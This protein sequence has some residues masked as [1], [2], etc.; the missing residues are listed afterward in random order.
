MAQIG[1]PAQQDPLHALL[2]PLRDSSGDLSRYCG[3]YFEYA[4]CM[5]VP[6]TILLSLVHMREEG[7]N[8]L[9]E[10]QERSF[11]RQ[12]AAVAHQRAVGA[13]HAMTR[14]DD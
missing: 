8:F 11:H 4:N 5:S 6:G 2:Q 12:A 9:F 3:Y 14:D 10:R 7:G 13:D 1:A